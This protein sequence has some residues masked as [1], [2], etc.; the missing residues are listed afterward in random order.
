MVYFRSELDLT[1]LIDLLSRPKAYL[2]VE[3]DFSGNLSVVGISFEDRKFF[4]FYGEDITAKNLEDTLS[5]AETILTFNGE[6][7]DLPVIK[8]CLGLDLKLSHKSVDLCILKRKLK[9]KGGLKEIE[10]L[11]GI[12]RRT[13]GV[14]S[15]DAPRL[16]KSYQV[17][18][19]LEAL[20]ILLDYNRED[21]LNLI[22]L[23]KI[24]V[25]KIRIIY[26]G[27]VRD[28]VKV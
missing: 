23:E 24:L 11:F 6:Y 28:R 7:F 17:Y 25:R 4:Q 8:R 20:R 2:D 19:D 13:K 21:V 3:T 26:E 15:S 14:T 12:E 16:W 27:E 9:I 10:E 5:R 18:G 1:N 22:E